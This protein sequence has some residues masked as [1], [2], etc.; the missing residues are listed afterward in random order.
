M[1][2]QADGDASRDPP[3]P[4]PTCHSTS[5][6]AQPA[7]LAGAATKK[8]LTAKQRGKQRA[9]PQEEADDD[10]TQAAVQELQWRAGVNRQS[11]PAA[12]EHQLAASKAAAAKRTANAMSPK[13]RLAKR[14]ARARES[15]AQKVAECTAAAAVRIKQQFQ[16]NLVRYLKEDHEDPCNGEEWNAFEGFLLGVYCDVFPDAG[17]FEDLGFEEH[18]LESFLELF[19]EWRRSDRYRDFVA[20]RDGSSGEEFQEYDQQEQEEQDDY[21]WG[22]VSEGSPPPPDHD[23]DDGGGWANVCLG[24]TSPLQMQPR[25]SSPPPPGDDPPSGGGGTGIESTGD[26]E[27]RPPPPPPPPPPPLPRGVSID[28]WCD[29]QVELE[30]LRQEQ[31]AIRDNARRALELARSSL[32][33][34]EQRMQR[35][36]AAGLPPR[37]DQIQYGE[38]GDPA[39]DQRFRADRESWYERFT[40]QSITTVSLQEQNELCDVIARRYRAYSDGRV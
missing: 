32:S 11:Q 21:G 17:D 39:G 34:H 25:Q 28:D 23:D 33:P 31:L 26:D 22:D 12:H 38:R 8:Q 3:P 7:A 1:A 10:A 6:S 15:Y 36:Q 27:S 5:H 16:R 18:E 24:R 30:Y 2:T 37:R 9:E 14:N 4:P 20:C 40:G 35:E 29:R 19:S 13:E